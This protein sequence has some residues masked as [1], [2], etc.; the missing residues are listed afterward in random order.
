MNEFDTNTANDLPPLP[1]APWGTMLTT[2][3]LLF[4]FAALVFAVYYA[5]GRLDESV[6]AQTGE[7]QLQE[8]RDSERA[9]LNNYGY[10]AETNAH[11]IPIDRAID[12]LIEE[13]KVNKGEM[14]SFPAKPR[15]GG[16]M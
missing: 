10:D 1:Q 9:I 11:R 14:K 12:I 3:A 8:L 2:L 7:Q 4:L 6:T 16:G 5:S 13:A 15:R